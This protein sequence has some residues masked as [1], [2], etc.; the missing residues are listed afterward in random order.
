MNYTRNFYEIKSN[1]EIFNRLEKERNQIGYFSLPFQDVQ[2]IEDYAKEIKSCAIVIIGIGGSSLGT[3]AIYDFLLPSKKPKKIVFLDTIDPLKINW[4]LDSIDIKKAHYI[5]VSKSGDTLE[6]ICI[7]KYLNSLVRLSSSNTTI[8]SEKGSKLHNYSINEKIKFFE[9]PKNLGGRFSA[10]SPV[11]LVPLAIAGINIRE[12]LN[13]ARVVHEGFFQKGKYYDHIINKARFL[14]ENKS[15]FNVNVLFAYSAV[16]SGF[17]KWFIQLWAESLGKININHTRQGLTPIGLIGPDDQHSFLQLI[18]DGVRD[19]TV[20]F[21]KINNLNDKTIIPDDSFDLLGQEFPKDLTFNSLL[22]LQADSTIES[23]LKQGKIP[24]DVITIN[25][26]DEYNIA[27]LMY[28]F[29]LLVSAIGAFLQINTYD[30][31]A[32]EIGKNILKE[33]LIND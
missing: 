6:P 7:A 28:R 32:V 25:T 1:D 24:C 33:K 12:L 13:G 4:C 30:Q 15:R 21:L 20:T 16:F 9:I 31:P 10:L 29:Q 11:G 2:F 27:K 18:I 19:K 26:V 3:R 5:L 8:I 23:V 22:N 14:V 17:N